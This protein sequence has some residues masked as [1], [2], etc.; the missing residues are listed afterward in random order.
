MKRLSIKDKNYVRLIHK[1][2]QLLEGTINVMV[3]FLFIGCTA[4]GAYA[5]WDSNQL[6]VDADARQYEQYKPID[7]DTRSF[8]ELKE[9]NEEVIGWLTVYGTNIDYP[10]L[11]AE[12]N[13]TYVNTSITGEKVL[14]GSIFLDHRNQPDFS[15]FNSIIY[16]HH[17]D[18]QMMF[19]DIGEFQD[20]AYF[21]E[22]RYGQI[23][24]GKDEYGIEFF[25]FVEADG[26]DKSV[27]SP[28]LIKPESQQEY[29]AGILEKA[30]HSRE[31]EVA[32]LDR[33]VLLSTCTSNVTNGRHILVGQISDTLHDD[34]FI[35]AGMTGAIGQSD[36]YWNSRIFWLTIMMLVLVNVI[37][38]LSKRKKSRKRKQK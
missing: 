12:D 34:P 4:F 37:L 16:G 32:S 29:L 35:K 19:G 9:I 13:E 21:K 36:G 25:A 8:A 11:Q 22:R 28:A 17:M 15:D 38:I 18:K 30:L 6:Y 20:E 27:Y 31:I 10:L 23:Y 24:D 3:L 5:M 26:Y 7:K 2:V 33:L 1:G 14:S